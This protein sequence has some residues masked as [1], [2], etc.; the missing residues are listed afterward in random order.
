LEDFLFNGARRNEAVNKA[1][2]LLTVTPNTGES[3]LVRGRIP[4][5]V[6]QDKAIGANKIDTA[7]AGL[8]AQKEDEFLSFRVIELIDKLLSFRDAHRAVESE[9]PILL[10]SAKLLEQIECLGVI[11]D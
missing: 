4:V 3:L 6:K 10:N 7:S 5:R 8:A 11:T 9:T 2:F 1:F